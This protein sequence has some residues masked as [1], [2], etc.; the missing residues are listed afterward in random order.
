[1]GITRLRLAGETRQ[2]GEDGRTGGRRMEGAGGG[3][4]G[5]AARV[6]WPADNGRPSVVDHACVRRQAIF[7]LPSNASVCVTRWMTSTR[8]AHASVRT[9][10]VARRACRGMSAI[11][12]TYVNLAVDYHKRRFEPV[13]MDITFTFTFTNAAKITRIKICKH[14]ENVMTVLLFF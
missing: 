2:E 13:Y 5:G 4:S 6:C 10:G 1:M 3:H 7:R 9:A 8:L 12:G 14:C 11:I